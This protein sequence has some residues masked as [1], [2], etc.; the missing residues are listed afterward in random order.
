MLSEEGRD[1]LQDNMEKH[2]RIL[3]FTNSELGKTVPAEAFA[4]AV[5]AEVKRIDPY[6]E[7]DTAMMDEIKE[8]IA[9]FIAED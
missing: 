6:A 7:E 3:T 5:L 1:L 2:M 4:S 8:E 9:I